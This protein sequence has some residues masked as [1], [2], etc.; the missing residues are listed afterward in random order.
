[1]KTEIIFK[2]VQP[3]KK[4]GGDNY[5]AKLDTEDRPVAQYWPQSISRHLSTGL[6]Y[7]TLVVTVEPGE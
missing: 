1:M 6:I 4:S 5:E 7:K 2:L 3:A